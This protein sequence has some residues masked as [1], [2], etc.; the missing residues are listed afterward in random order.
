MGLMGWTLRP[1]V[2]GVSEKMREVLR[3]TYRKCEIAIVPNGVVLP[4]SA[5]SRDKARL[6]LCLPTMAKIIGA[7]GRLEDVKGHDILIE[8]IARLPGDVILVLAGDGSQRKRLEDLVTQRSLSGRVV[9][10]GH[11]DDLQ[12]IYPAFDVFCQP[13][14]NEGLPLTILEAQASGV[15]VVASAVGNVAA[16]VCPRSGEL[17]P[18]GD[19]EALFQAIMKA[20][21]SRA[22]SPREFIATHFDFR[23][24]VEGYA[25]II[26][27][28]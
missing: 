3:R 12:S 7:A 26:E 18:A 11:R 5:P 13:S 16:G 4:E 2:I 21:S 10:L 1:K 8:A 14:R 25:R 23:H 24:T 17:V 22:P 15:R 28:C 20:F 6:A 19:I 27:G 9:F